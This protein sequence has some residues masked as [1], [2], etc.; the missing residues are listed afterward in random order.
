MPVFQILLRA[1]EE[2]AKYIGSPA[3]MSRLLMALD[4]KLRQVPAIGKL[5]PDLALM[6]S[7]V[8]CWGKPGFWVPQ[9]MLLIMVGV[10]IYLVKKYY[11]M[12]NNIPVAGIADDL[13]V[14]G[15]ALKIVKPELE[16]YKKWRND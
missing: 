12:P 15:T 1:A 7:E 5:Y 10:M 14:V 3:R 11:L 13:A 2:A 6:I 9:R 16:R 8:K 4:I